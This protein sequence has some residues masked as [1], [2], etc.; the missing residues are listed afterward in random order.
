MQMKERGAETKK[1]ANIQR[2]TV[3]TRLS[4][5]TIFV[6]RATRDLLVYVC[7]VS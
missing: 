3:R 6:G 4:M 7:R 1:R 5:V 2:E